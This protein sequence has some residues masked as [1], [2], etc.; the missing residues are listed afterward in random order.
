[1]DPS[2][3]AAAFGRIEN[4]PKS[5]DKLRRVSKSEKETLRAAESNP[6]DYT[7]ADRAEAT[8]YIRILL[9]V[10]AETTGIGPSPRVP[11]IKETLSDDD[12]IEL[13]DTDSTGVL[14]HYAIAK[15][16]EIVV[17]LKERTLKSGV[18][19][20]TTFYNDGGVLIDDYR[21]LVRVLH[22]GGTGDAYAQSK[23]IHRI[24]C[25]FIRLFFNLW[26]VFRWSG[27]DSCSSTNGG[28]SFSTET[29]HYYRP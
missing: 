18:S 29:N 28:M 14:T 15:L 11:H 21:P 13:L 20:A 26:A 2:P 4:D 12:A 10:L 3:V 5:L 27:S 24:K 23:F 16:N 9:K 17:C 25:S 6:L 1:M 19:V 8:A 22:F 7:L